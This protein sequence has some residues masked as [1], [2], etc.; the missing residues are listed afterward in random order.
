MPFLLVVLPGKRNRDLL[1]CS[2]TNVTFLISDY[3][4]W[5]SFFFFSTARTITYNLKS[6][7]DKKKISSIQFCSIIVNQDSRKATGPSRC[8][9]GSSYIRQDVQLKL[10]FQSRIEVVGRT[11]RS[12]NYVFDCVATYFIYVRGL[13]LACKPYSRFCLNS[14]YF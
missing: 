4:D 1:S 12:C 9:F 14:F 2:K 7:T 10:C 11:G 13:T 8:L 3:K 5:N 6:F